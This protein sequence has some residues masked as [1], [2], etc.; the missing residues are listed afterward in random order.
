MR[1]WA[2][3]QLPLLSWILPIAVMPDLS[4]RLFLHSAALQLCCWI[5]ILIATANAQPYRNEMS[6]LSKKAHVSAQTISTSA[7]KCRTCSPPIIGIKVNSILECKNVM[8]IRAPGSLLRWTFSRWIACVQISWTILVVMQWS[9][10]MSNVLCCKYIYLQGIR[11]MMMSLVL[12][13]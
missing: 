4:L 2:I 11:D 8:L 1:S 6:N 3:V 13:P 12:E 10:E 7:P 5:Y 9:D